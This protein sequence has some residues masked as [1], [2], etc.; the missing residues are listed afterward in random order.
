MPAKIFL[1]LFHV[2]FFGQFLVEPSNLYDDLA[3]FVHGD[4]VKAWFEE[5]LASR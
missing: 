3:K 2:L 4:D 1:D 5:D